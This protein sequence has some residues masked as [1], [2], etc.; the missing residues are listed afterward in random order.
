[1]IMTCQHLR[2]I[3]LDYVPQ[4]AGD[5]NVLVMSIR[6]SCPDCGRLRFLGI[7]AGLSLSQPSTSTDGCVLH[8]P[9]IGEMDE[10]ERERMLAS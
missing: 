8:L 6:V 2:G 9:V 1:M 4:V 7:D 5:T 10:P 3:E